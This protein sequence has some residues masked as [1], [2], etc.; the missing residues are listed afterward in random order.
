MYEVRA[1]DLTPRPD[2]N[3]DTLE[4]SGCSTGGCGPSSKDSRMEASTDT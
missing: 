3:P 2:L 4:I 1:C